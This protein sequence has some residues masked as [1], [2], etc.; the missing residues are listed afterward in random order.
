MLA[1]KEIVAAICPF[2]LADPS[3]GDRSSIFYTSLGRAGGYIQ[4]SYNDILEVGNLATFP[5]FHNTLLVMCSLLEFNGELRV[6]L[7]ALKPF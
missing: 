5:L 2:V 6:G 3:I 7:Y 4:P 1:A